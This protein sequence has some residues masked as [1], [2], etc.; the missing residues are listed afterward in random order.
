MSAVEGAVLQIQQR[1]EVIVCCTCKMPFAVL[2]STRSDWRSSGATFYC[3]LG[4]QQHYSES[5]EARLRK[6]KEKLERDCAWYQ[7]RLKDERAAHETTTRRLNAQR[8]NVTKLKK[9]VAHGV[10]PCCTRTFSNL[11]RHMASQ[12]PG[13]KSV[14]PA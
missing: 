1:F 8:A 4:H 7:E 10:C 13:F 11:A 6:E 9:R 12:H 14:E 5:L 2:A 3:P